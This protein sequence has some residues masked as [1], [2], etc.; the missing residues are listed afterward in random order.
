MKS[1]QS[2]AVAA[3][4][5][6]ALAANSSSA[7]LL[8]LIAC[9]D[10]N[11]SCASWAAGGECANNPGFMGSACRKS[12][13]KCQVSG[14][15]AQQA[16]EVLLYSTRNLQA[17]CE[18]VNREH[19]AA[20][21]APCGKALK[22]AADALKLA[23]APDY[24]DQAR[25]VARLTATATATMSAVEAMC[26]ASATV[27]VPLAAN[28]EEAEMQRGCGAVDYNALEPAFTP[29]EPPGTVALRGGVQMPLV[30]LGTWMTV[31]QAAVDLVA[32]GLRAGFRAIDTSENYANADK[33]G[34]AIAASGVAR[35]DLFLADKVSFPKS[36][37]K[38]GVR[39]M[40][41]ASLAAHRTEYLDL[42]MLHSVGPGLKA[43]VETYRE[44][45]ALKDEGKVRAVGVSNFGVGDLKALADA[46]LEAPSTLQV[47][48]NVL[49][50]GR[51]G[52]AAGE[53]L[54]AYCKENGIVLVAYC[55]L[56]SWPSKLAP[57]AD[58]HVAHIAAKLK[59]TPSQVLLRWATQQGVA[60]LTRSSKEE[61]LREAR[62][63]G[64]AIG[65]ADMRLLSGLAWFVRSRSNRPPPTVEDEYDVHGL[66]E[67][68][69]KWHSD[70]KREAQEGYAGA[71]IE[72]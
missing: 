57:I 63:L 47:K 23:D 5:A 61:R 30:G 46:G 52:N 58:L 55:P 69:R 72:L 7:L 62:D 44:L 36:Y 41:A 22:N 64:F 27:G 37:S 67:R 20:P 32:S 71:R 6:F 50:P 43:R 12:C 4:M 45:L 42:L 40:L 2:K 11:P 59:R 10:E 35:K 3:D 51:T 70:L 17:H 65:D 54:L 19:L 24:A 14:E 9:A 33:V 56:N 26:G 16:I 15:L 25:L 18:R 29:A 53:D 1:N 49:H 39:A 13:N 8:T 21:V 68:A 66:D 60:V 31:G 48:F 38:D 28:G 34:E